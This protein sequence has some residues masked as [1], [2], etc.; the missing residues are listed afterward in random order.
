MAVTKI[1]PVRDRF[2]KAL[3]YAA[4]AKKTDAENREVFLCQRSKL[5]AGKRQGGLCRHAEALG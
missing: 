3:D 4:N 2:D 1:W 5:S